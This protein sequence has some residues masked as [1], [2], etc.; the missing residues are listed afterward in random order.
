MKRYLIAGAVAL[1]LAGGSFAFANSLSVNSNTLSSGTD[2]VDQGCESIDVSYTTT[3]NGSNAYELD[4]ISLDGGTGCDA[5]SF[6]VDVAD[7]GG[8]SLGQYSGSLVA[9]DATIDA[10]GDAIDAAD[11]ENISAVTTG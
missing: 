8:T 10:S 6:T 5:Q 3:Y 11:V 7:A 4:E 2:S 9:G 1:T